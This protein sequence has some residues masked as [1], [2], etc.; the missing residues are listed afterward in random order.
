MAR[1]ARREVR[2][3]FRLDVTKTA[4]VSVAWEQREIKLSEGVFDDDFEPFGVHVYRLVS[5]QSR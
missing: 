5:R 4:K 3:R 2:A 1:G